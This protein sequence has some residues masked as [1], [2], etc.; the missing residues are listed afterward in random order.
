MG[1]QR[2]A[3]SGEI[4]A[5]SLL[6]WVPVC[7]ELERIDVGQALNIEL[8]HRYLRT[9]EWMQYVWLVDELKV[10]LFRDARFD[11]FQVAF[12]DEPMELELC[13]QLSRAEAMRLI[14]EEVRKNVR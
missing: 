1:D 8:G 11:I 3:L 12:G 2:L 9:G 13:K 6:E 5:F 4:L 14:I 10:W 7:V